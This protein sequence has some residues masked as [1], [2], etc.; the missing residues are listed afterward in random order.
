MFEV[1][2][3]TARGNLLFEELNLPASS[4][5]IIYIVRTGALPFLLYRPP[6]NTCALLSSAI[7]LLLFTVSH[8]KAFSQLFLVF[9]REVTMTRRSALAGFLQLLQASSSV[10]ARSRITHTDTRSPPCP[11]IK[12]SQRHAHKL[13]TGDWKPSETECKKEMVRRWKEAIK[14]ENFQKK[15]KEYRAFNFVTRML[16]KIVS[17]SSPPSEMQIQ[18]VKTAVE[19]EK[20]SPRTF[21]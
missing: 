13:T 14:S 7:F 10:D 19:K 8:G 15:E 11:C 21:P 6:A 3:R 16:R 1:H 12:H 20:F 5:L 2:Y 17:V 4:S 18:R 9:T